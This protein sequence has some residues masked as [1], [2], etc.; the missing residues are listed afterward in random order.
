MVFLERTVRELHFVMKQH[1]PRE[2]LMLNQ[3]QK[4]H[5]LKSNLRLGEQAIC[6]MT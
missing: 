3:V 2:H 5:D 4:K 6:F 1:L